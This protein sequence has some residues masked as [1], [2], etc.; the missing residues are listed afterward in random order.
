MSNGW[1]ETGPTRAT[2][3]RSTPPGGC[4]FCRWPRPSRSR[5]SPSS[6]SRSSLRLK[7][8]RATIP[9]PPTSAANTQP[10]RTLRRY[11]RT[12]S[13]LRRRR[14]P[15][16]MTDPRS[17]PPYFEAQIAPQKQRSR[18]RRTATRE[19]YTTEIF[20]WKVPVSAIAGWWNCSRPGIC[21]P[22]HQEKAIGSSKHSTAF[23]RY[24]CRKQGQGAWTL[25]GFVTI[26][27]GLGPEGR[28]AVVRFDRGDGINAMSP[29]AMRQLTDA[30]RSFEDD[31]ATSVVV[32]T[33]GAAKS[34]TAGF[35]LKDPEGQ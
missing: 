30:A 32:L 34:F 9:C 19:R 20:F 17:N 7:S 21:D 1:R 15:S 26:E 2:R 8:R 14:S 23:V 28:I 18:T 31:S 5:Q 6:G 24:R 33:G 35:D 12:S 27:K 22:S 10:M 11:R 13:A 4:L 3:R 16:D 25:A 29:E